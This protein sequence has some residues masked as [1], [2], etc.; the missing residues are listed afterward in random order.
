MPVTNLAPSSIQ[1]DKALAFPF[2]H[3]PVNF[4][5]LSPAEKRVYDSIRS[6]LLTGKNERVMRPGF[7]VDVH[8]YVFDTLTPLMQA[9]IA[10]DVTGQIQLYEPRAQVISVIPS[11]EKN[12]TG[13]E[14]TLIIDIL[15]RVGNQPVQQQV[16]IPLT[17][18]GT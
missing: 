6:L 16:P 12:D 17:N 8:Q 9:R 3:G 15:Y 13:L 18:K 11:L 4:P 2:Q 5:A 7:G 1:R 10:A 14:T